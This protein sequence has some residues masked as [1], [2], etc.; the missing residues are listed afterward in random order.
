MR[1]RLL[2]VLLLIAL[3]SAAAC[4]RLEPSIPGPEVDLSDPDVGG[5]VGAESGP[6]TPI[7]TATATTEASP[8]LD[9]TAEALATFPAASP[10]L[11]LT[12]PLPTAEP[13]PLET[14]LPTDAPP[15][16][17]ETPPPAESATA[18]PEPS[19]TL[20]GGLNEAGE[21]IHTV[22]AGENLY[23]IGL[24]Y[25]ISWVVIA[26]FNGITNPDSIT[27]GQELRIPP[28]PTATAEARSDAPVTAGRDR[29]AVDTVSAS[30]LPGDGSEPAAQSPAAVSPPTATRVN[31]APEAPAVAA[32]TVA[33]SPAVEDTHTV[34]PGDTL[35]DIARRY[36]VSWDQVAEAN[37]LAAANQ[38]Y[39]GQVLK[40]PVDAPG[41]VHA[42]LHHVHR[43][44]TL[45]G[46]ARQ[47]GL[48]TAELAE[49][50]G[51]A[52]PYV[53]YPGQAIT[54]PGE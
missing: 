40:I 23:R 15:V 32:V 16:A 29:A 33:S 43:G 39:A 27:V 50:N 1:R 54:I 8:R 49:A 20:E 25:G 46:I 17:T 34:T 18:A 28:A 5:G 52:A 38:I 45:T 26:E 2:A 13:P 35:Y 37:G 41:P 6:E 24:Q 30:P 9:A 44:D 47:Y 53:I 11:A 21:I 42:I 4:N 31:D 36:G 12:I 3:L 7:P 10:T 48:T 14:P 22:Q 19:P 51:L